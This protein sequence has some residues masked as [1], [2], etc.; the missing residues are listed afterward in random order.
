MKFKEL[1]NVKETI[2]KSLIK[3]EV[4]Y[5]VGNPEVVIEENFVV[6][7]Y[8]ST[9]LAEMETENRSILVSK[10]STFAKEDGQVMGN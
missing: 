10:D 4:G 1:L 8:R 3:A 2:I 5:E 7:K 9:N 6:I